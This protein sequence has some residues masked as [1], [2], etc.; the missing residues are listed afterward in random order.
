MPPVASERRDDRR[1]SKKSAE[2]RLA[3]SLKRTNLVGA[4]RPS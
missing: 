1:L 3:V 4:F 2:R